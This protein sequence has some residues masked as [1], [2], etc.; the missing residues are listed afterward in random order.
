MKQLI[1]L[2]LLLL[3]ACSG[4]TKKNQ[5]DLSKEVEETS[6]EDQSPR[7]LVSF[8]RPG[9]NLS[10]SLL[11]DYQRAKK[12]HK[13]LPF[14]TSTQ[15]GNFF[16]SCNRKFSISEMNSPK[17][18]KAILFG[19]TSG[20][21]D[22]LLPTIFEK[23]GNAGIYGDGYIEVYKKG[24]YQLYDYINQRLLTEEFEI[25]FPSLIKGYLA[26]GKRNGQFFKLYDDGT[27]ILIEDEKEYP[28]YHK[29]ADR[30]KFDVQS[31]SFGLWYNTELFD[32][33]YKEDI[34]AGIYTTPSYLYALGIIQKYV[35]GV[36]FENNSSGIAQFKALK[37]EQK[38]RNSKIRSLAI[39][40][41]EEGIDSR[42]WVREEHEL[43]TLDEK[44][45]VKFKK[46][47]NSVSDYSMQNKCQDCGGNGFKFI[48]D[49]IIEVESWLFPSSEFSDDR[50][51]VK[52]GFDSLF[53]AMSHFTYYVIEADGK[54]K[55]LY[56]GSLFPMASIIPL[57][58]NY[59][60]G[61]FLKN[62]KQ[63]PDMMSY[64]PI[65]NFADYEE[66]SPDAWV[67]EMNQLNAKDIRFVINEIYARHGYI[68]G[69]KQLNS[70]F[71]SIKWY[72][73]R[74]RKVD[75]LLTP[76]EKQNIYFLQ[77]IEKQLNQNERE[78]L[79]AKRRVLVWAG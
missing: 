11:A 3:T 72:K 37:I 60:K 48:N 63:F 18:N 66:D 39:S 70:Y 35:V 6:K 14:C 17:W 10:N 28:S 68:F 7:E 78:Q 16:I 51:N 59:L 79:Q 1:I 33:E 15:D 38:K 56:P 50:N 26:I 9:I 20:K 23:I 77:T 2:L 75:Q 45:K 46:K 29:I 69:D 19:L 74:N 30:L 5:N 58:K 47:L 43:I 76:L 54:I 55:E 32:A 57:N 22:T 61:C 21:G 41:M 44:S 31:D 42:G 34:D 62:N 40:F 8:E 36:A 67:I 4:E 13:Y 73:P 24:N 64:S 52:P 53:V 25:L 71:R 27:V 65:E 12:K 49:S